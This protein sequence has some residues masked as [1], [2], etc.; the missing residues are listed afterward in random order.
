M[1]NFPKLSFYP[2]QLEICLS[3]KCNLDCDYCFINK[4]CKGKLIFSSIQK[5]IE[6]FFN[7]SQKRK[8]VSFN[9]GEPLIHFNLL[10]KTIDCLIKKANN[11]NVHLD[12]ILTTNGILLDKKK[13]KFLSSKKDKI[14]LNLSLDGRKKSHDLHRKIRGEIQQSSFDIIWNNIRNIDNF[15]KKDIRV[16]LT[17]T[18]KTLPY[19]LSNLKFL[20][21]KGFVKFDFFPQMFVFWP[22]KKLKQLNEIFKEFTSFYISYLKKGGE[23]LDLYLLNRIYSSSCY[24]KLLLGSDGNFYLFD[25]I[26]CLPISERK[27]YIIGNIKNGIDYKKRMVLFQQLFSEIL[28]LTNNSCLKCDL[29]QLCACPVPIYLWS[30]VNKKNFN[31][32]FQNFCQI[33]RIYVTATNEIK[34]TLKENGYNFNKV[35]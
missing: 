35:K 4:S 22:D 19:L 2:P 28:K 13:L 1:L 31:K 7:T 8:L 18:P 10:Q 21:K 33:S 24:N 32:L 12:I 34:K 3:E 15:S 27:K 16:I 14:I 26:L 30:S 9:S 23:F 11:K 25:G 20:I 6:I 5:G 17:F 29:Q